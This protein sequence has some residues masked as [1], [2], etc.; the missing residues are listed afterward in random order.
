MTTS[1]PSSARQAIQNAQKA[2]QAG[3]K[4]SA[5]RWAERAATL[6]PGLEE[7]WLILAAVAS[8]RA[9]LAYLGQALEIN[10]QSQRARRG[11][12]W[13]HERLRRQGAGQIQSAP[14]PRRPL[15]LP[16]KVLAGRHSHLPTLIVIFV[17]IAFSWAAWPG[18]IL[19]ALA[20][21]EEIRAQTRTNHPY[22]SQAEVVK[23]T[24]TPSPTP[25]PTITPTPTFTPTPLPTDTPSPLSTPSPLPTYPSNGKRIVVDFSEQHLYAYEDDLLVYSFI[26]STGIGNST[27]I[28]TFSVLNKIPNA[29]GA[30]WNI[31]M[32][33]W[34]GIY[35]SGY[36]QNGIHALPILPGGARLWAGYLGRPVSY[37]CVVLGVSDA[38]LLYD[39]AEIGTVVEI[40]R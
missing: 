19:P 22:G 24:Y 20:Q 35:W 3:D 15:T 8:P 12:H 25:T 16:D 26:A 7:P 10:P 18:N 37:G 14:R 39:W 30:S 32:P 38:R 2:L 31:W 33:D 13:A 23:P 29:Y 28:G 6:A 9:S 40:K 1:D 36:L 17:L 21:V 11:M 4:R 5:R 27:R 34:L